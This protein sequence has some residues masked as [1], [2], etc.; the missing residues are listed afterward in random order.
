MTIEDFYNKILMLKPVI[1][2]KIADF[3]GSALYTS[4]SLSSAV[5]LDEESQK[6][7]NA[8][9][10]YNDVNITLSVLLKNNMEFVSAG[11]IFAA[12]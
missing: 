7:I 5:Y 1:A 8:S 11:V 2:I 4:V 12:E 9:F 6:R 3:S 10:I